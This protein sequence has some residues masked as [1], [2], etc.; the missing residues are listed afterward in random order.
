M[1]CGLNSAAE[2]SK[3]HS[4]LSV[5]HLYC[6]MRCKC[7]VTAACVLDSVDDRALLTVI[8]KQQK[9]IQFTIAQ[10]LLKFKED[11]AGVPYDLAGK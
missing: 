6:P 1:Y 5:N 8:S 11:H 9:T 2:V 3:K 4:H 7:F 10:S